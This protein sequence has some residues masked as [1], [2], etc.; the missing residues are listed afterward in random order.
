M[1]ALRPIEGGIKV[2]DVVEAR[3]QGS[4]IY[5]EGVVIG[6]SGEAQDLDEWDID[7]GEGD[8]QEHVPSDCVRKKSL[9]RAKLLH[10]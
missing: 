5:C 2:G 3:V 7:F 8:V 9:N 10:T 1:R 4:R 6:R